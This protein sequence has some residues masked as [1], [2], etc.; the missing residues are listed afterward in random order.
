MIVDQSGQVSLNL[1]AAFTDGKFQSV[2]DIA[3]GKHHAVRLAEASGSGVP[4]LCITLHLLDAKPCPEEIALQCGAFQNPRGH[5]S[6]QFQD[7]DDPRDGAGG[8]L[9]LQVDCLSDDCVEVGRKL[10]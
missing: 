4:C 5:P 10:L 1:F 9:L 6:F 8:N 2:L 3:L 7:Q